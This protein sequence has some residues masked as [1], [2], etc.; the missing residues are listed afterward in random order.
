[1]H[2]TSRGNFKVRRVFTPELLLATLLRVTVPKENNGVVIAM[3]TVTL[4]RAILCT[5]LST[6]LFAMLY[7]VNV[8]VVS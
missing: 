3:D 5:M 6:M 2:S 4:V 8:G 1:M 7:C